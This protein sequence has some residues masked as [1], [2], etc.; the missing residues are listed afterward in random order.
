MHVIPKAGVM[1]PR[2]DNIAW[3][4][5]FAVVALAVTA[6]VIMFVYANADTDLLWQGYYHDRNGHYAFGQD[7]ALAIRT[8][9]PVWFFTEFL[10]AQ[11]WPPL[12]GLTVAAVLL[13]GG[14]DHRL[15]I[16]PSLLGWALTIVFVAQIAR[17]MFRDRVLGIAAAVIALTLAVASPAFRLLA[18]D[19][20]LE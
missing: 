3:L 18:C 12:H 19:V 4:F 2:Q 14:I 7:L 17:H 13:V 6:A 9:D 20:M 8:G 1:H 16:V 11:I 5:T 15:G 10:K